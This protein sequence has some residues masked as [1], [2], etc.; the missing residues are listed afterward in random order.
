MR[1]LFISTLNLATNPRFFKEIQLALESG[2]QVELVCFEFN[3]WSYDF[4]Q[5]L[6]SELEEWHA[7]SDS[8]QLSPAKLQSEMHLLKAVPIITIPAGRSPLLPWLLSVFFEKLFRVIGKF[9]SLPDWALSQAVSRRSMLLIRELK[10]KEGPFDLVIGHNPGAL[11]PTL[12][13]AHKLNTKAG[14]DIEDYHPGEGTKKNEQKLT[15]KIIERTLP[16]MQYVSFASPLMRKRTQKDLKTNDDNWITVLNYF[17]SSEFT[18]TE[19]HNSGPLK[20]VWFSQNINYRR[21]LEQVIPALAAFENKIELTLIGNK[22]GKFAT[23]F[24]KDN[25]FIKVIPPLDQKS[26]HKMIGTFDVGLA[27]EPGKDT[28]NYIALSNKVMTYFQSGLYI[29]ASDTPAHKEL[30]RQYP[31]HG[32]ATSLSEENL[33]ENL[34]LLVEKIPFIR[35]QKRNRFNKAKQ[36]SWEVESRKLLQMWQQVLI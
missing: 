12:W 17:D 23:E 20:L 24:L 5:T 15:R 7:K 22:K 30:F 14:F 34:N 3:N 6:K 33:R 11:Y 13:A 32:L 10:K 2:Y 27:I 25:N 19:S 4:N 18:L 26:L 36:N 21:G 9:I 16:K 29:L 1:I 8:Y 31:D 35:I 28:N